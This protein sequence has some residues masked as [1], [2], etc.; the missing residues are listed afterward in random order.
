M[1][2]PGA[3]RP[4]NR[5]VEH[6]RGH[7]PGRLM[8]HTHDAHECVRSAQAAASGARE[9]TDGWGR[10]RRPGNSAGV[11]TVPYLTSLNRFYP[12]QSHVVDTRLIWVPNGTIPK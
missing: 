8:T 3:T 9:G 5:R 2:S 4:Q 6:P 10:S 1:Q 12:V 11:L 7:V